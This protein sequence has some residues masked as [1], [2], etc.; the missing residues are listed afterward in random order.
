MFAAFVPRYDQMNGAP[1]SK[2]VIIQRLRNDSQCKEMQTDCTVE[3][4]VNRLKYELNGR[5]EKK[6]TEITVRATK[7]DS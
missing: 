3:Q 1:I 2:P 5:K 6:T 4:V 7:R